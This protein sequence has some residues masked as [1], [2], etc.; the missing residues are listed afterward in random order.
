MLP[1]T[2][3]YALR[4]MAWLAS[5]PE[6]VPG[7]SAVLAKE[8]HIPK[9]YLSKLMRRLVVAGLVD[10]QRGHGGGF[11]LHRPAD[12]IRFIEILEAVDFPAGLGDCAFGWETCSSEAPCPLHPMWVELRRAFLN[13]AEGTR[14]SQVNPDD[15]T[16]GMPTLPA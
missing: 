10:S 13:W 11:V 7:T 5:L 4:A 9:H 6:G 14:L 12:E 2:T 15:P 3:E 16:S 8:T 1:K